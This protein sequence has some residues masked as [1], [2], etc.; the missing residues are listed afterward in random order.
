MDAGPDAC[1]G[2]LWAAVWWLARV[3][4]GH[5]FGRGMAR[6][7]LGSESWEGMV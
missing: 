1:F 4:D 5:V 3:Y 7:N 2:A 6:V